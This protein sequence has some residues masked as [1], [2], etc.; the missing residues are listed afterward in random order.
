MIVRVMPSEA[1]RNAR[2]FS[3]ETIEKASSCVRA[4]GALVLQ[5]I[6]DPALI[7]EARKTFLQ[8][9]SRYLNGQEH[10]DA[11]QV[12]DRRLQI[13]VSFEP[14]FDRPE[15]FANAWLLQ[16]LRAVFADD[17]VLGGYGVVC[18]LPGAQSQ[19]CHRDGGIL[20]SQSGLDRLLPAAAITVA[21]PLLDMNEIHGTTAIWLGSH[22]DC[23]LAAV[24][25]SAEKSEEPV[26]QEGSCV[27]WDYRVAHAGTPNRST[28]P[29]PLL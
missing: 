15:L 3:S 26:V 11:L 22:R 19:H 7:L 13:T 27:L 18:S 4:D 12:G 9:Y 6:V 8:R 20:F 1:E 2:A 28:M 16:V 5:G 21:I 24:H 14:P 25:T 29:R 23:D 10:G 17:F